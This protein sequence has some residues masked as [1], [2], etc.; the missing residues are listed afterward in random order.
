MTTGPVSPELLENEPVVALD[1][2]HT[3]RAD[4]LCPRR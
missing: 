2:V 3:A 1:D 4:L